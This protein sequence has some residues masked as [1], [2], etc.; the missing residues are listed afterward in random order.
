MKRCPRPHLK[1][2]SQSH[3]ESWVTLVF[4]TTHLGGNPTGISSSPG[5]AVPRAPPHRREQPRWEAGPSHHGVLC[6]DTKHSCRDWHVLTALG[7]F[8]C[9]LCAGSTQA[10][11]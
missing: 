5:K 9:L 2:L 7:E 11:C 10:L 4:G 1:P 6:Q 8:K 3:E